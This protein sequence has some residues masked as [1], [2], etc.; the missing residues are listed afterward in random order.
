MLIHS[1]HV[2]RAVG[3]SR[4]SSA[5]RVAISSSTAGGRV[6]PITEA[7]VDLMRSSA[8]WSRARRSRRG[9]GL[10][11]QSELGSSEAELADLPVGE[12]GVRNVPYRARAFT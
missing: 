9:L 7:L 6:R 4:M 10:D 11:F 5:A 12:P 1:G 3:S 2:S 8:P